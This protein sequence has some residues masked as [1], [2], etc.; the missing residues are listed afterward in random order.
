M[1]IPISIIE[2]N[3]YYRG[4]KGVRSV[5]INELLKTTEPQDVAFILTQGSCQNSHFRDR[6]RHDR[7]FVLFCRKYPAAIRKWGWTKHFDHLFGKE[8]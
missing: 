2:Y 5:T 8:A 6:L 4:K 3:S 7:E 1:K